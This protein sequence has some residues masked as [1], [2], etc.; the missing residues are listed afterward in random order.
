MKV[1]FLDIDGVLNSNRWLDGRRKELFDRMQK[2]GEHP[3]R[4]VIDRRAVLKVNQIVEATSAKV[5]ISSAW[6][7]QHSWKT[8][9]EYLNYHGFRGKVVGQTPAKMSLYDRWA[10]I[11]MWLSYAETQPNHIVILDD[12]HD[13]GKFKNFHVWIDEEI[14][15]QDEHVDKAIEIL[16]K[17]FERNKL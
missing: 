17:P 10:E 1:I 9:Q 13:M 5:V 14:G 11:R 6:R 12:I 15:L 3:W 7:H 16:S 4:D 2:T 8:M